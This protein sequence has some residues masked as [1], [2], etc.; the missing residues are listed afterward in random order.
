MK[1]NDSN[2][3]VPLPRTR[4]AV[5]LVVLWL[6]AVETCG[7]VLPLVSVSGGRFGVLLVYDRSICDTSRSM[8]VSQGGKLHA[9]PVVSAA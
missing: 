8:G 4:P 1:G 6:G 3:P 2:I 5:I 7:L 9:Q